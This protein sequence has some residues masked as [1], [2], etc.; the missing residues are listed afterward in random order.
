MS[1]GTILLVCGAIGLAAY[2]WLFYRT[3]RDGGEDS[4]RYVDVFRDSRRYIW[5]GA[6]L[7]I[8]AF[9]VTNVVI[10]VALAGIAIAWLGLTT[11]AQHKR[12]RELQF[13]RDFE[14]SLFRTSLL[15]PAAIGFLLASK[16]WF[17]ANVA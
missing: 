11:N 5:I 3:F 16:W 8:G 7:F 15:A 13:G 6:A 9:A 17:Q 1:L 12:M 14:R 2:F 4:K 10:S